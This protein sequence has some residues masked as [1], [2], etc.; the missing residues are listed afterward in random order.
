MADLPVE[1]HVTHIYSSL[2]KITAEGLEH[3]N[4]KLLPKD[5]VVVSSRATIGRIGIAKEPLATNQGFKNVII[6]K[7]DVVLPEFL[8]L[9]LREKVDEMNALA[10]GATF[11][12]ISKTNFESLSISVPAL[13]EQKK[14]LDQI[15]YEQS[16]IEPSKKLIEV[17]S[18]KIENR[19][20]EIW[21][22]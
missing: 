21:G 10:S 18:A 5:T 11:K 6:K 12:E 17:F 2:R 3:S 14:I 7:K 13:E 8:A 22:D 9:M 16:L 4:A 15:H 1:N 19:I 20:K